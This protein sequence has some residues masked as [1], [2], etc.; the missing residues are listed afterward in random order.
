VV[1]ALVIQG[2]GTMI[3]ARVVGADAVA[4]AL[5][6]LVAVVGP[7]ALL[8]ARRFPGPTVAV[9]A[10]ATVV[11]VVLPPDPGPP[12]VALAIAVVGGIVRGALTWVVASISTAWVVALVVGS[13][14]AVDWPPIRIAL[15]TF[16]LLLLVLVGISVRDRRLRAAEYRREEAGRRQTAEQAERVRIARELHDVL[17]H[18]LSQISVQAGVGLH[19][20]ESRPEEARSALSSIKTTSKDALDEVRAVLGI[21]RGEGEAPTTPAHSIEDIAE[22]A[23]GTRASGL[24]VEFSLSMGGVDLVPSTAAAAAYRIVQEALTN[25]VRHAGATRVA[26]DVSVRGGDLHVSVR[27]DGHGRTG[28]VDGNGLLG[29]RERAALS[30]GELRV[31]EPADGGFLVVARLPLGVPS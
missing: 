20:M 12:A 1:F 30:G 3:A 4:S 19:L 29:M 18:S 7:L 15:S 8:G 11:D 14:V 10:L 17:A 16:A 31:E 28:S 24:A 23:D 22:L 26:V 9:V 2:A 27:D 5:A 21:L 13:V 25:V 6:L